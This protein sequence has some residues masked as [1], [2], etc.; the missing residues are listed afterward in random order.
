MRA[1]PSALCPH[2]PEDNVRVRVSDNLDNQVAGY[3]LPLLMRGLVIIPILGLFDT[4]STFVSTGAASS[5]P[6]AF[7][8]GTVS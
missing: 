6:S 5:L 7:C 2:S 8:Q 3:S 1:D 4:T